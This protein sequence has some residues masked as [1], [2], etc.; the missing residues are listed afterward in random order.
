MFGFNKKKD[1][2]Q[3]PE[4]E[5]AE[6]PEATEA[7]E[8]PTSDT[9]ALEQAIDARNGEIARLQLLL[10]QIREN[11]AR[12]EQQALTALSEARAA[13]TNSVRELGAA[14]GVQ[15]DDGGKWNFDL[16]TKTFSKAE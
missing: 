5:T 6:A 9:A 13:L 11:A 12:Q 7:T 16:T 1:E 15:V 8:A 10:G 3:A 2:E 14:Q 4:V